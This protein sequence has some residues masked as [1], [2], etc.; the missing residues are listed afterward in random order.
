M[1]EPEFQCQGTLETADGN[2]FV[3]PGFLQ[4]LRKSVWVYDPDVAAGDVLPYLR[5]V[6][7][8]FGAA[9][10]RFLGNSLPLFSVKNFI[11]NDADKGAFHEGTALADADDLFAGDGEHKFQ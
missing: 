1:P 7:W 2:V 9:F 8:F 10:R 11:G 6:K 5:Q 3:A 4:C